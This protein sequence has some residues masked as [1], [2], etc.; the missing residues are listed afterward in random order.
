ML[1]WL[2]T[3]FH[4]DLQVFESKTLALTMT[5]VCKALEVLIFQIKNI[6]ALLVKDFQ[7][8]A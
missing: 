1:L 7:G 2:N 5:D 6:F 8:Q 4:D 3:L